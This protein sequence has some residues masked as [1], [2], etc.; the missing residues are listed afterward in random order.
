MKRQVRLIVLLGLY[1]LW[2]SSIVWG[3]SRVL[4][5]SFSGDYPTES[6]PDAVGEMATSTADFHVLVFVHPKCPCSMATIDNLGRLLPRCPANYAVTA[7]VFVPEGKDK[8]W[9][10]ETATFAALERLPHTR[11]E[12]DTGGTRIRQW[13]VRRSGHVIVKAPDGSVA[14]SG[15]ITLE[16]G[17]AGESLGTVSMMRVLMQQSPPARAVPVFGCTFSLDSL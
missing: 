10:T 4:N 2:G 13:N 16:R 14:F 17:H 15:G 5:Y 1:V 8:E 7:I 3:V 12:F 9:A 6:S 11:I